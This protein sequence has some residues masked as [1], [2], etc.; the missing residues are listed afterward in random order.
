M[1]NGVGPWDGT[2]ERAGN[3]E[4]TCLQEER[5]VLHWYKP[6]WFAWDSGP[7]GRP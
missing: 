6:S 5:M 3:G 4:L 1:M 2:M 7:S